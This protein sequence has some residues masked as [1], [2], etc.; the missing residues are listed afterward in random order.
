SEHRESSLRDYL[1]LL[2]PGVMALVVFTGFV[3]LQMAPGHMHPF[4]Q[5][6]TVLAIAMGSG[7]GAAINMWF[8]ADIDAIMNRTQKRPIP[9]G[10][11]A[12]DDALVLGVGLSIAGVMLIALAANAIAAAWLAFAIFFYAVI[13]TMA[14]KR[15]TSQNIVIG[16]AAG[17]FPAV[18]GWAAMSGGHL[19]AL[20]WIMFAIVFLWTPPHFW[21]LA[22]YRHDDYKRAHIPMLPVTA[23]IKST[24]IHM[25]IYT[26]VL[27]AVSLAPLAYGSQQLYAIGAFVLGGNFLRHAIRVLR[28]DAPALAMRMFGF[29]IMY[30]F[31]LF[32]LLFGDHLVLR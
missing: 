14:L 32:A 25:L 5:A 6:L 21:A 30:L 13:Y 8:D 1:T 31:A 18:I 20:P 11:I 29:S 24:K 26:L 16:G 12:K 9:A 2:K 19:S 22:L 23:G 10:R 7:G 27:I 4:M 28:N 17:A 3:G 15:H